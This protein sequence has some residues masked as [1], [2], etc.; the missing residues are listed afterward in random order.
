M[1]RPSFNRRKL[2]M[3][4]SLIY[5]LCV[6]K[7]WKPSNYSYVQAFQGPSFTTVNNTS[8]NSFMLPPI[9]R[10]QE[11]CWVIYISQVGSNR[12]SIVAALVNRYFCSHL[13]F[14]PAQLLPTQEGLPDAPTSLGWR[15]R[16]QNP[17]SFLKP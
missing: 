4:G 14:P 1:F 10:D 3:G 11:Y 9:S 2:Q 13:P 8:W 5:L 7:L 15:V 6:F 16:Y 12:L 17:N